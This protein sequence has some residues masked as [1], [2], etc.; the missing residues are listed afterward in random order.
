MCSHSVWIYLWWTVLFLLRFLKLSLTFP[1]IFR[2]CLGDGHGDEEGEAT[3]VSPIDSSSGKVP[4]R[5]SA[6]ELVS[7]TDTWLVFS[8]LL[9]VS[10]WTGS[11]DVTGL[12]SEDTLIWTGETAGRGGLLGGALEVPGDVPS[13]VFKDLTEW[14]V[15][16]G[17]CLESMMRGGV[18]GGLFLA[19]L[20]SL[21]LGGEEEGGGGKGRGGRDKG[22]GG[23]LGGAGLSL[24][25]GG[26]GE[27]K[28]WSVEGGGCESWVANGISFWG[29][30]G[31]LARLDEVF[32]E[33]E[34]NGSVITGILVLLG[35]VV[36]MMSSS[37]VVGEK[38]SKTGISL[39]GEFKGD[40]GDIL[41]IV[42]I[43]TNILSPMELL[44]V[45]WPVLVDNL[46]DSYWSTASF[47]ELLRRI[48]LAI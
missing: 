17:L 2:P 48:F 33:I 40:C 9:S 30:L 10:G 14:G 32:S 22:G 20:A 27:D 16:W 13:L 5:L 43:S 36:D 6:L 44:L 29:M 42:S 21:I 39:V 35:G 25:R 12:F 38:A 8:E 24:T 31:E 41:L 37:S 28:T 3:E 26:D 45:S 7:S 18:G 34:Y 19:S 1:S 4:I 23:L 47:T 11:G 46:F 15:C